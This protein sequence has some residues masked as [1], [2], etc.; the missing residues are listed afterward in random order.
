MLREFPLNKVRHFYYSLLNGLCFSWNRRAPR[1]AHLPCS[2]VTP[3]GALVPPSLCAGCAHDV[4][5]FVKGIDAGSNKNKRE[6]LNPSLLSDQI[7]P[8]S[9]L[10][11]VCFV[12]LLLLESEAVRDVEG[13]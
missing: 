10:S 5:G 3:V 13:L 12:F 11:C 6:N 7:I 8:L 2:G 9:S 4:C 1:G